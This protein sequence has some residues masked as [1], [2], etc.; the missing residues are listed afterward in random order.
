MEI[1]NI[2][3]IYDP[4]SS[5]QPALARGADIAKAA[6]GRLHVF[7]CT[8]AELLKEEDKAARIKAEIARLQ[9]KLDELIAPLAARG[10]SVTREVEWDK[11]WYQAAVRAS[12]R[13]CADLVLK[14]SFSHTSK[15]RRLRRT[16]D[17]ILMRE[18][19]CP[20][21]LVKSDA[22]RD[23]RTV[24]AAIDIHKHGGP[25]EELNQHVVDFSRRIIDSRRAEVHFVNAFKDL[26]DFPDR[27]AL[28]RY[29]GVE[30]NRIHIQLGE[31]EQ[32]IVDS[33]RDLN[34]GL[35]VMGNSGRSGLSAMLHGN[36]A[37][38]VLDKLE[39]DV[40]SMP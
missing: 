19:L 22:P 16:S 33:A 20:V 9:V 35:V 40:L 5:S 4:T 14:S 8:Y 21:L 28:S 37:E 11:D 30:S 23:D 38:R 26:K 18:C 15:Q 6:S 31:P 24:L 25:H 2:F 7:A 17:W 27:N 32:V 12:V 34:A 36:T 13:N 1:A 3:A 39:C 29:C 10:I